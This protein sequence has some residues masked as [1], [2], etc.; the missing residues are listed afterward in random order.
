MKALLGITPLRDGGFTCGE[1]IA[2]LCN[3]RFESDVILD[4]NQPMAKRNSSLDMFESDVILDGNQPKG[5]Q[6]SA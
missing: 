1:F 6:W 4:G 3:L 2:N 5:V